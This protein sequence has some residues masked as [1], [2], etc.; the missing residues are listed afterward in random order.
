MAFKGTTLSYLRL[1]AIFCITIAV[2][3]KKIMA[4][5]LYIPSVASFFTVN[6]H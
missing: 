5:L 2:S 3:D 1:A 4:F 6:S